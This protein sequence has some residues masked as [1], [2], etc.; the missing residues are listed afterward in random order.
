[1]SAAAKFSAGLLMFRRVAAEGGI[2]VLLAHPGG[3]FFAKKDLGAWSIPKGEVDPGEDPRA[4]AVRE[5]AEE[6]GLSLQIGHFIE[7]GN[8][9]QRGGKTVQAWAFEGDC[10]PAALV[11]NHFELEWPPRSGRLQ[12]FP[13]VDRLEFFA[14]AEARLKIN[15]AQVEL[16]GRLEKAL[17]A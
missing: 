1:M 4:C 14:L 12:S 6:T 2:E 15:P 3:P 11:S 10:D 16:L 13:E 17:V 7:L 8:I 5:F 9:K